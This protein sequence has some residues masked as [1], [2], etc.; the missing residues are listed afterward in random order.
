[1]SKN[2]YGEVECLLRHVLAN[3]VHATCM[4]LVQGG[5]GENSGKNI[6]LMSEFRVPH[7]FMTRQEQLRHRSFSSVV[8]FYF[9]MKY[10][11]AILSIHETPEVLHGLP[12]STK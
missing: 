5:Y 7:T 6:A 8:F 11:G 4:W 1:M 3:L 2:F 9:M 12:E 10:V